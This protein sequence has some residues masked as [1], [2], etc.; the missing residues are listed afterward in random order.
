MN[1][2]RRTLLK[3]LG[4]AAGAV[5][6]FD[7]SALSDSDDSVASYDWEFGDDTA[8]TGETVSHSYDAS[9]HY[10]ATLTVTDPG[11]FFQ[12]TDSC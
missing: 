4:S 6:S 10:T 12:S 3:S 9:G 7:G 11:R 2:Q 5:A 1:L 8:V